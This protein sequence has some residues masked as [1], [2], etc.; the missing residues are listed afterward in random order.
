MEHVIAFPALDWQATIS[1]VAFEVLGMNIY[2]YG[3]IICVGAILAARYVDAHVQAFGLTSNHLMDCLLVCVPTAI[4]CARIYYVVFEWEY[5]S[6][7]P[8]KIVA[9]RDGG[10]AIYGGVIGAVLALWA[11]SRAKRLSFATL[12]DLAAM[13]LLIGQCIGRWGNFVNGEAHGGETAL[14]WG[15]SIDGAAPVHPTF[16]YESLWNLAG[17]L[18]LHLYWKKRRF[19]GELALLYVAWYGLGRTWIEGLRTDSLYIGA[20]RVSQVLAAVSCAAAVA[21]L[22][23]QYRRLSVQQHFYTPPTPDEDEGGTT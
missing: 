3:I 22:V 20:F 21:L 1:R 19:R 16:L 4:V 15:M 13:G 7:H 9:I 12:C 8:A 14:P 10:L 18:G 17:F 2:W 11:Y 6:Q 23:R 5:Y